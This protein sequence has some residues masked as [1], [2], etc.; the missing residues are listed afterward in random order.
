MMSR[1]V[2]R[3]ITWMICCIG[4]LSLPQAGLAQWNGNQIQP[5]TALSPSVLIQPAELVNSI[6]GVRDCY[7]DA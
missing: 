7:A 6:H 3:G 2:R 5:A 4:V 1:S